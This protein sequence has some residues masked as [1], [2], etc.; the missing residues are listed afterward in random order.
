MRLDGVQTLLAMQAQ[1][2]GSGKKIIHFGPSNGIPKIH[3]SPLRE[4][5][6]KTLY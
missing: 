3:S 2:L 1:A 6:F 5:S 4:I